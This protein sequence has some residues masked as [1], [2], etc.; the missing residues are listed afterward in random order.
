MNDWVIAPHKTIR[1]VEGTEYINRVLKSYNAFGSVPFNKIREW[2]STTDNELFEL[3]SHAKFDKSII[4]FQDGYLPLQSLEFMPWE[5]HGQ[6]AP[7]LTD[8]FFDITLDLSVAMDVT[9]PL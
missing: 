1:A 5:D 4:S 2:F 9:T 7:P 6:S 8:H 3:L